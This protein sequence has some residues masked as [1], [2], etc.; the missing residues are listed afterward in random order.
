MYREGDPLSRFPDHG[1]QFFIS[2]VSASGGIMK[3]YQA[4][5]WAFAL[6]YSTGLQVRGLR[7]RLTIITLTHSH[8][9]QIYTYERLRHSVQSTTAAGD[10]ICAFVARIVALCIFYPVS[11]LSSFTR[12]AMM[13]P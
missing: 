9:G 5:P 7:E 2:S 6:S 13:I 8:V 11:A 3:F 1:L 4:A 10:F 12:W